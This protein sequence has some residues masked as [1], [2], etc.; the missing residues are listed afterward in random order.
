MFPSP[1]GVNIVGNLS[2]FRQTKAL[3]SMMF[4]SPCGV[5][6]VG[7]PKK[8]DTPR[9]PTPRFPSPCGVNIVGNIHEYKVTDTTD[10]GGMVSVPLLGKYC[11]ECKRSTPLAIG[12]KT[13]GETA[14][15]TTI[16]MLEI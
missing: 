16:G 11:R 14:T 15:M 1:C 13:Q 2:A 4:P 9:T 8:P 10:K 7:N 5:N 6:I 3:L 12:W